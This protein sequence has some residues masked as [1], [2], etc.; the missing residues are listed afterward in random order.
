MLK[1]LS[2]YY[3]NNNEKIIFIISLVGFM[4]L[5]SGFM[6]TLGYFIQK[7]SILDYIYNDI[8]SEKAKEEMKR[9]ERLEKLRREKILKDYR[10]SVKSAKPWT[11]KNGTLV[12]FNPFTNQ[13][14][15]LPDSFRALG[16]DLF[17]DSKDSLKRSY[18]KLAKKLHPDAEGGSEA[19]F[20]ELQANYEDAQELIDLYE[21]ETK[22]SYN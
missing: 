20:K 10:E 2:L 6:L 16:F 19:L 5:A 13:E 17:P 9:K 15:R 1:E 4:V 11:M 14:E 21:N 8:M 7:K 3:A 22:T 18:R 12:A